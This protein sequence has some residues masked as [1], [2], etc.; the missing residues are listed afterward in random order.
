MTTRLC[1]YCGGELDKLELAY[2]L[3]WHTN[4]YTCIHALKMRNE[5]F[6]QCLFRAIALYNQAHPESEILPSADKNFAWII[7]QVQKLENANAT[8][9]QSK[10]E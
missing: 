3:S 2:G 1:E 4:I 7:E 8:L 9:I 5:Y 10:K 6:E